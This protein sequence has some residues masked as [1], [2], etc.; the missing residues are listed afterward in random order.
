MKWEKIRKLHPNKYVLLKELKS[1]ITGNTRYVDDVELIQI[2]NDSM[3][4][5]TEMIKS[6]EEVFVYHTSSKE[7]GFLMSGARQF[8]KANA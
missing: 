7:L 3:A 6:R 1:H 8:V 4:A 2:F 5:V